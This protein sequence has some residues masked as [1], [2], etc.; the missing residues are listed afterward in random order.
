MGAWACDSFGNDDAC[1]W[2]FG[3][4]KVNDLSLV[5]ATIDAVLDAE[6]V[7]AP[8]ASEGLAAIEVIARLQGNGG[9]RNS[10]SEPVDQWVEKHKIQ[11]PAALAKKAHL[12]IEQILSD[13]SELK[14]LWKESNEYNEWLASVGELKMR[15]AVA[16]V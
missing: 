14:E 6:Y 11:V 4:K 16:K 2:T 1:D 7:E 15:V 8:T 13:K 12:A 3:L 9:E 10:Y 5:E